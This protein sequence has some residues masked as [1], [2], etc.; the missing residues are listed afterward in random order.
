MFF[1]SWY[2]I[3]QVFVTSLFAF[4]ILIILLRVSGKRTLSKWNAFDYIVTIAL[5]S[6]LASVIM[7]KDIV[8]S[9]GILASFLLIAFQFIITWLYV[10]ISWIEDW[11]K[12]KPTLLYYKNQFFSDKM[13]KQRVSKSEILA[14]IRASGCA[15]LEKIEVVVL[16]TDGSFSVIKRSENNE[17]NSALEDVEGTIYIQEPSNSGFWQRESSRN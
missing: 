5:G 9:E 2:A 3:V 7:S 15:S 17:S 16:E 4:S 6:I 8:V 10:R 12:A 14:A 13:K 1:D 11:I